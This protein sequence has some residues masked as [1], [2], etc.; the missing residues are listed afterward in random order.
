[1]PDPSGTDVRPTSRFT[2][3]VQNYVKARPG[4]PQEIVALLERKCGLTH[5]ATLVDVGCGTGLLARLFCDYGCR[6]VGVEPNAAMRDAG[7]QFLAPYANFQMIDGKA[8][9][10]PLPGTSADFITAGQAFHWFDLDAARH[11]FL[12]ILRPNGWTALIWNDREF[13]GSPFAEAYEKMALEF[14]T[15][16]NE[17]HQRGKID[18]PTLERFYGNSAVAQESFPNAQSLEHDAFVARVLSASYMPGPG[19]P[20]HEQLLQEIDRIFRE[21]AR[22]GRIEMRYAATVYYGQMS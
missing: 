5:R 21:N 7:R 16:Y 3:R 8:E 10:M 15:D 11:E 12:R 13:T 19:H 14:G 6:V 17:V 2:D 18:T 4:Y 1:M 20:R 22:Q 9:N